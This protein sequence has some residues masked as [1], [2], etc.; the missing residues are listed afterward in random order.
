MAIS[1]IGG[2]GSDNWELIS[3][4][5]PTAASATVNFTGLVPY[6]KL[7]V[8]WRG[9]VLATANEVDIRIN[10][11]SSSNVYMYYNT[12]STGG[13]NL[14]FGDKIITSAGTTI[15]QNGF[16][17]IDSCDNTGIKRIVDGAGT[18]NSRTNFSGIYFATAVVT[19]I[20]VLTDSTFTAVGT[21]ALYGVK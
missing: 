7:M 21:V 15:D 6:R 8:V 13:N 9:I 20:N 1:K 14:N 2:T 10:N 11:D 17:I 12:T 3:S 19:Q 5:T 16:L 4:V 18:L